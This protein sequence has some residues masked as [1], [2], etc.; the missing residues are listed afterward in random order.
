MSTFDK[1]RAVY[2]VISSAEAVNSVPNKYVC[3]CRAGE[4]IVSGKW[5]NSHS[6]GVK[7]FSLVLT[8]R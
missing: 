1:R 8:Y 5:H 7:G 2:Y 3:I 6:E 4:L